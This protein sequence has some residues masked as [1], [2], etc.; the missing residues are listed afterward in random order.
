MKYIWKVKKT[1]K[2]IALIF[3][4]IFTQKLT[5]A[6]TCNALGQNPT[7]A[8]PVCGTTQ[9]VQNTVPLCGNRT[10]PTPCTDQTTYTDKN[11]YWYKF[12]CYISGK[13]GFLITPKDLGDDY[14][15]ELFDIT[16][17]DPM[18]VYSNKSLII[19]ANWSGTYGTTGADSTAK[20]SF[21][22]SSIPTN[23]VPTFSTMPDIIAGHNYLLLVSHFTNTQ[24]G[25]T[26]SFQGGTA[27]IINPV[28][29]VLQ[30]AY[31][32]CDGTQ[33]IVSLNKKMKC[34]SLD[35][36]GSDFGITGTIPN[37]VIAATGKGCDVSFDMDSVVLTLNS[38]LSPGTYTI[39]SKNGA[40]GNTL[41]DDCGNSL[42]TGLQENLVFTPAA[43]TPMDS[44]MPV[45]CIQDTLQLI[46]NKPINCQSIAADGTDFKIT[47]PSVVNITSARGICSN[48]VTTTIQLVLSKPIKTNGVYAIQLN[49][50]SDGNT[51]I[52]ECGQI[53]PPGSVLNFQIKNVVT[54]DFRYT[55]QAGCRFDTLLLNHDGNNGTTQWNWIL[56]DGLNSKLQN[57]VFRTNLFGQTHAQLFVSNGFCSDSSS[58]DFLLTDNT[59]KAG[60][61]VPDTVCAK[62]SLIILDK[63]GSNT[64]SWRWDFGNG[65]ASMLQ[66]PPAQLY[67]ISNR[68]NQFLISLIVTNAINCTDTAY[69]KITV[70]P[71]C[72]IDIPDAFTPN[73]DGL[74]DYLYPLNAFKAIHL[75]FKVYNRFG[76]VIFETTDWTRKWDG[77]INGE[78]QPSGVYVWTLD[79]VHKDTGKTFSL[80][81]TTVLIR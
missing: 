48:G 50:G 6:Q 15:W 72:Y 24:S 26:L 16:G 1:G 70:L 13:L 52:N 61:S 79:Y 18:D 9:F 43:P 63:S 77:R 40:D 37:S 4:L 76:Q 3:I 78:L 5:T 33:I 46:F 28:T 41:M 80:K 39:T 51:L 30:N 64:Q 20:N 81:G 19:S 11:P 55:I 73:G 10:I 67:Q 62:D 49:N 71:N 34:S 69:K 36:D 38:V 59:V 29:P 75:N 57:P 47:G 12:T 65:Q 54:A 25:Y 2:I 27:S 53:T 74:N 56:N 17:A 21:E 42:A 60:F 66:Q 8:F 58:A 68:Q 44:I 32:V 35:T 7:T 14:D 31:A 23:N 22:C 45:I